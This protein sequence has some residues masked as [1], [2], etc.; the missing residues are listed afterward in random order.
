MVF[1]F[2]FFFGFYIFNGL[3]EEKLPQARNRSESL[4]LMGLGPTRRTH[5]RRTPACGE[6]RRRTF[7]W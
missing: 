1:T 4:A 3:L 7:P 5:P 6:G 2:F